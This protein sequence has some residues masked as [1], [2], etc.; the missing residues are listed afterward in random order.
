MKLSIKNQRKFKNYLIDPKFQLKFIAILV[1]TNILIAL[2]ILG[3]MYLFFI[4]SSSLY[5]VLQYMHSDTSI[6]FRK[7]LNQYLILLSG[8]GGLFIILIGFIAL[9]LSHRAAGPIY[10]FKKIYDHITDGKTEERVHL[11][12]KDDFQEAAH[13]FNKMMDKI[14]NKPN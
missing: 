4:N 12:P 11:R 13:S 14:T 3:S 10:R 7:E 2:I 9:I 5:G 8:L 6:N 1:V